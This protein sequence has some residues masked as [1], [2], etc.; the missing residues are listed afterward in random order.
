MNA[1][2]AALLFLLS[3]QISA[4]DKSWDEF[5]QG[6]TE[7]YFEAH[8][9]F[10]VYVGRHEFDGRLPD[11]SEEGIKKEI[12]RLGE[13]KDRARKFPKSLEREYL[14]TIIEG[15]LFSLQIAENPR[16]N[17]HFYS[18]AMDPGVY[19]DVP[20]APEPKRIES[21]IRYL[22]NVPRACE[23]IQRTLQAPMPATFSKFG[24][25]SFGGIADFLEKDVPIAFEKTFEANKDLFEKYKTELKPAVE[26]LQ[27]LNE[28]FKKL[29]TTAG[30]KYALGADLYVEMLR[31][32]EGI[33]LSVSKLE[34]IAEAELARNFKDLR[35]AC[36]K[37]A[38]KKSLKDC[39]FLENSQ[40]PKNGP[41][42]EARVDLKKLKKFL[43][44]SKIVSIPSKQEALVKESQPYK[45]WNS[46]S[47]YTPGPFDVGMPSTYYISPPDPKW[48]KEE[49][50]QYIP[51]LASLADTSIH[52]V[53]P[54][55]FLQYLHAIQ[56]KSKFGQI[57]QVYSF[58]EGWAHY[59]EE[60]MSEIGYEKQKPVF[61]VAQILNALL[62]T[63]RFLSSIGLH[64]RGMTVEES[65]R[66]FVEKGL[67]D[68]ATAKQQAARGTFDPGYLSYTLGKLM[69]RKLRDDWCAKRGGRKCW[70]Q[71]HNKFLSYGAPPIP[72]IREAMM[73]TQDGLL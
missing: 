26:A 34:K 2:I 44:A 18:S 46:A 17:P 32:S 29:N 22:Q 16:R 42:V 1:L 13:E 33:D 43:Q 53:W 59:A 67:Q 51:G 62:R 54:G 11:W 72:L 38:P 49:Q 48:T 40:K 21:L 65:E 36:K 73:G 9:D 61:R 19:V 41:V 10:A 37:F 66:L 45:R 6:F 35:D 60:L 50:D 57:F 30:G 12:Q 14:L 68:P 7:R 55:H 28:W 5:V 24:S 4:D 31:R 25:L 39:A 23:Q 56:S 3:A 58:T 64:A 27:K 70:R 69:I 8:P 20:Y 15:E 47:I 71:F 63:A 52:E